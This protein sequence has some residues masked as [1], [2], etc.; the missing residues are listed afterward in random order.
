ME[1]ILS[2]L[3][4]DRADAPTTTM[5]SDMS[6]SDTPTLDDIGD[7]SF[8]SQQA[9]LQ[10]YLDALP[11]P[12]ESVEEMQAELARIVGRICVCADARNWLVLSTWDGLLQWSVHQCACTR[13]SLTHTTCP[14]AGC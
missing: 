10:S 8:E 5:D 2:L 14:A 9:A 13:P 12:C 3:G 4:A 6:G 1:N 11:Y 7:A